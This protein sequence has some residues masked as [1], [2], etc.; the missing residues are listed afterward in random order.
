MSYKD[1]LVYLDDGKSNQERINSAFDLAKSQQAR[2]TGITLSAVKPTHMIVKAETAQ[3]NISYQEAEKR[4]AEFSKQA[5][6]KGVEF[7]TKIIDLTAS[8]GLRRA[9]A[10]YARNFDLVIFRQA[11]PNNRNYELIESI[12]SKIMVHCGRPV[13][14]MPYIGAHHIPAKN[15]LIAWDGTATATRAVHDSLPILKQVKEVTI[16]VVTEG[17]KKTAKGELLADDLSTHLGRHGINANVRRTTTGSFDVSTVLLNH[18]AE[19]SLDL[20]IMGS[21]G[22]SGL[23]SKVF[24]GVTKKILDS[25]ITPVIMSH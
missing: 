5:T 1:I 22:T 13:F 3:F 8:K 2:L 15:A 21:Y 4:I 9:V 17:K 25:M 11:N 24:G 16:L 6:E 7:D 10:K 12:A 23:Q 18:I 19:N 14:F 20:L